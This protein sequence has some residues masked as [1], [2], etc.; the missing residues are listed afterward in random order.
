MEK[1]RPRWWG[2]AP[3]ALI[4]Q[5]RQYDGGCGRRFPGTVISSTGAGARFAEKEKS[6]P[7]AWLPVFSDRCESKAH[8]ERSCR[9]NRPV[10]LVQKFSCV[11]ISSLEISIEKNTTFVNIMQEEFSVF[12]KFFIFSLDGF[13]HPALRSA[14]WRRDARS[15]LYLPAVLC[16]FFLSPGKYSLCYT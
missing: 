2:R 16:V 9:P 13:R 15:F 11:S 5:T 6:T 14:F 10:M 1:A 3:S 12:H 8:P 7:T 4:S